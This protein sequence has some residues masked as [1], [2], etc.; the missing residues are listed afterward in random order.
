[1]KPIVC[2]ILALVLCCAVF[3]GCGSTSN[4]EET[5]ANTKTPA[6]IQT[7]ANTKTPASGETSAPAGSETPPTVTEKET[8][9]DPSGCDTTE[10]PQAGDVPL[11]MEAFLSDLVAKNP[12][13]GAEAL[14]D[15]ILKSPYFS[16]FNKMKT[17]FY[18]PGLRFDYKPGGVK[19]ACAVADTVTPAVVIIVVPT[20]KTDPEQLAAKM[21]ENANPDWQFTGPDTAPDQLY[22]KTSD[23][24]VFFAMYG[25]DMLPITEYAE[26]GSDY[27][28]IF[29]NYRAAH[30]DA[31]CLEMAKYFSVRG[32][33]GA[34]MTHEATE[35]RLRGFGIWDDSIGWYRDV[36]IT[37]FSEGVRF[38]PAMEPNAFLGYVFKVKEGTDTDAFASLLREYA[39]LAY[40]VCTSVHAVFTATDGD[41]VLFM[42]CNN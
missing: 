21:K 23:G 41:Y 15:E 20:E 13:A 32:K 8:P 33:F 9:A 22:T 19:E 24:K 25:S 12:G 26:K 17:D 30:P 28:G 1:M 27:I 7:P 29:H 34:M 6:D 37:G 42:M 3:V 36:E 40:N 5:P 10:T 4:Q 35:G 39:N 38:E 16:L 14:C 11:D 2:F 18:W 31:D